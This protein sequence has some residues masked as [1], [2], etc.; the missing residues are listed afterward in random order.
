[1]GLLAVFH[2][3]NALV[4]PNLP[5][6]TLALGDRGDG[7][8]AGKEDARQRYAHLNAGHV[9]DVIRFGAVPHLYEF[10]CT[11]PF[12]ARVALGLGTLAGGGKP[13]TADGW[14]FAFGA[15][16][17]SLTYDNL[18]V[19]ARGT[20][21]V[22]WDR[23]TGDGY[24]AEFTGNAYADAQGKGHGVSLLTVEVTGAVSPV[25]DRLLR[26]LDRLS[27]LPT[28]VDHTQYN[29]TSRS[30]PHRFY[31]HHLEELVT[32]VAYADATTWL[33]AAASEAF[34]LTH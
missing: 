6:G 33:N 24:V 10:K 29:T 27:R 12:L 21:G 9:P 8:P 25:L 28:T 14:R 11:T 18:G 20:P 5:D 17:E 1:M 23:L 15:T 3:L 4:S 13:C 34:Q 31:D 26:H 32:A 19:R 22:Q 30:A 16:L 2:A 7:T